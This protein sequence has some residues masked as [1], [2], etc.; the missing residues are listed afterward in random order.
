MIRARELELRERKRVP[1]VQH[2]V[3]VR[4]REVPEELGRFRACGFDRRGRFR[5]RGGERA[6]GRER[7]RARGKETPRDRSEPRR[8]IDRRSRELSRRTTTTTTTTTTGEG[9]RR[10]DAPSLGAETSKVFSS[11]HFFCALA[12]S[13]SRV[14]RRAVAIVAAKRTTRG[15]T[16]R[17]EARRKF[18][19]SREA[20]RRRSRAGTPART[21]DGR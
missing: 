15:R 4:V 2:P 18:S 14:S 9:R 17:S 16:T 6:A 5:R 12:W 8:S 13:S 11:A 10:A 1:E 7:G 3:H 21:R 20:R 19:R